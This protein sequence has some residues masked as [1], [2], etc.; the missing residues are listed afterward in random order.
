MI[1][2]KSKA[3]LVFMLIAFFATACGIVQDGGNGAEVIQSVGRA[4]VEFLV[5]VLVVAF[6]YWR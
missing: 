5:V 3:F 2:Q 1:G 4:A 6:F